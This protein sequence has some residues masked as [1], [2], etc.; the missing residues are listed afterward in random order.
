LLFDSSQSDG[1]ILIETQNRL[2][3]KGN[4]SPA[5]LTNLDAVT[6]AIEVA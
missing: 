1:A 4:I 2:I 5:S 6:G 3:G